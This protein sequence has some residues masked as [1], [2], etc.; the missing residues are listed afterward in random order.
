MSPL[1]VH[2]DADLYSSTLYV[3]TQ[4]DRCLVPGTILIF[5]E[6]SQVTGEFKAW[7][8]YTTA[9]GRRGRVLGHA[10]TFYEHVAIEVD[11]GTSLPLTPPV[12]T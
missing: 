4:L 2:L 11:S 6:F 8:D 7:R 9:Y 1:I 10:G 12:S 5:D 3:L